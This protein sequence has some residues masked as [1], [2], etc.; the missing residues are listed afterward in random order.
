MIAEDYANYL[1]VSSI[2]ETSAYDFNLLSRLLY[3]IFIVISISHCRTSRYTSF[4]LEHKDTVHM[5]QNMKQ[6]HHHH[7]YLLDV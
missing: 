7:K 6:I 3:T 1:L 2:A 5:I 4:I